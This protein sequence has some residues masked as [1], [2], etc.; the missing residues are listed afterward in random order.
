LSDEI[1]DAVGGFV[2]DP[3]WVRSDPEVHLTPRKEPELWFEKAG[4]RA[5][6][7]HEPRTTKAAIVTCGGLCPGLNSVIRSLYITLSLNYG[8][9]EIL[10]I[11]HGYRGLNPAVGDTP[12]VLTLGRVSTIHKE[13]GTILGSSRGPQPID[14]MVDFLV[15]LRVNILFC[16][17]GDGTLRG[18]HAIADE[19]KRRGLPISIIGVPKTIDNDILHSARSFGLVTSVEHSMEVIHHAHCEAKGAIRGIGLVK[20][21]GRESGYIAAYSTLASQEANFVLV[22]EIP[23]TMQ[24]E[25]GFLAVLGQRMRERGHAVIVVAEGAGQQLFDG[26]ASEFDASGNRKQHDIGPKLKSDIAAHFREIG[27]PVEIKYIDPS[28]IIR[29]GPANC[30]DNLLCGQLARDAVHAAM[31]GRTDLVVNYLNGRF[32]HVPIGMAIERKQRIDPEGELWASVLAAT[33]QP[34]RFGD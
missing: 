29:S 26:M 23:F 30:D 32:I 14:K 13:G 9:P 21:M 31:S 5:K 18:A 20:V 17:G 12:E 24:G 10:G 22:P 1:G 11:R 33:G 25:K 27:E 8:V 15:S 16:V 6:L 7:F 3:H 2:H 19:L 4:P 28:Y 34:A